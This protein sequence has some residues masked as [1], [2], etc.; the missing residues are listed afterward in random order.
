[1]RYNL[2]PDAQRHSWQTR[3]AGLPLGI[4]SGLLF[5]ISIGAVAAGMIF[6]S[7]AA[8]EKQRYQDQAFPVQKQIIRQNTI[9]KKLQQTVKQMEEH[10][11]EYISWSAVLVMLSDTK[12]PGVMVERLTAQK[13]N[14]I[15]SGYT[16][17][18]GAEQKW[19]DTLRRHPLVQRVS[20]S[21]GKKTDQNMAPFK[22]EV[23]LRHGAAEEETNK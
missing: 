14:L 8:E 7:L 13:Q 17:S 18:Q 1:M 5:S 11:K 15:L 3:L 6:S 20:V 9:E 23:E 22:L 12:P 4:L 10:Q 16:G 19:R 2:I 21:T